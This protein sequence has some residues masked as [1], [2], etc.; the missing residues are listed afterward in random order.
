MKTETAPTGVSPG[1][2]TLLQPIFADTNNLQQTG[3]NK[4]NG[5][6]AFTD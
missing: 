5:K 4:D 1:N 3:G 2:I 6:Y